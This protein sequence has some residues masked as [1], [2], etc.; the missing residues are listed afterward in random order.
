GSGS[1]CG[2]GAWVWEGVSPPEGRGPVVGEAVSVL[3]A[4]GVSGRSACAA[5]W[6]LSVMASVVAGGVGAGGGGSFMPT[7][8]QGPTGGGRVFSSPGRCGRAG[9]EG[10]GV[11]GAGGGPGRWEWSGGGG[12]EV[13]APVV[14]G[15]VGWG[16]AGSFMP[17]PRQVP[18]GV[19]P[20]STSSISWFRTV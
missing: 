13:V 17:T 12:R 3:G 11:G 18:T 14:E 15:G 4:G 2:C 16:G 19:A 8:S 10:G 6:G 5:V 20:V 9:G 1:F 7:P